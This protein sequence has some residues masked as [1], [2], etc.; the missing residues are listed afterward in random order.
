MTDEQL[1]TAQKYIDYQTKQSG[2]A[3]PNVEFQKAYIE[4]LKEAGIKDNSVDVVISN[5]VINLSPDKQAVFSEIFRVLKPGGELYFSDIFTGRRLPEY[6]K[7]DPVLYGE[8]L[9][10]A[11][12]REDF[13]RNHQNMLFCIRMK[14]TNSSSYFN[15][16]TQF[17]IDA[18]EF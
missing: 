18:G 7:D 14:C 11:L 5:C 9:A 12:Y 10:G 4:D 1:D 15:K 3:R 16:P 2:Y 6:L 13:R 8:C 17:P